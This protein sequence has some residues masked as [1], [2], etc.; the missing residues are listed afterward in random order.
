MSELRLFSLLMSTDV[1]EMK[2][3]CLDFRALLLPGMELLIFPQNTQLS[4]NLDVSLNFSYAG[5]S[6][7]LQR[8]CARM[9][10]S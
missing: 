4:L 5:L 9:R 3:V 6:A 2:Q 1:C 8:D 10:K 7:E